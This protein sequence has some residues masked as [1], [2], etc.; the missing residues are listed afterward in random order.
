M[1]ELEIHIDS[2]WNGYLGVNKKEY[3]VSSKVFFRFSI[4]ISKFL[5]NFAIKYINLSKYALLLELWNRT[6]SWD[7]VLPQLWYCG[8]KEKKDK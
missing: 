1:I 2:S 5:F 8:R 4:P 7:K 6:G 3:L